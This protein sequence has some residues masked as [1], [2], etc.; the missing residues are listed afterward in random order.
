MRFPYEVDD[1]DRC[2][3]L[4]PGVVDIFSAA[5]PYASGPKRIDG[6][7]SGSG[8]GNGNG[9]SHHRDSTS[10][11]PFAMA[12]TLIGGASDGGVG[13]RKRKRLCGW[14]QPSNLT[15]AQ[16]VMDDSSIM[17]G[18][19]ATD[20]FGGCGA[21]YMRQY[22][23]YLWEADDNPH[24]R[25]N[26]G[27]PGKPRRHQ[28]QDSVTC[29]M[30]H[31]LVDWLVDICEEFKLHGPSLFLCVNLLDRAFDVIN[32]RRERLQLLGCVV[33]HLSHYS[34][35]IYFFSFD[36]STDCFSCTWCVFRFPVCTRAH[37]SFIHLPTD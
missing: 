34:I 37:S 8:G 31:C 18:S 5:S 30:R 20:H 13:G 6:G 29:D 24:H 22:V 12:S 32:V 1:E 19:G 14:E 2:R 26:Q 16:P 28:P 17:G 33:R 15:C 11:V 23:A 35:S 36:N 7:G 21:S 9:N 25:P 3:R 27:S 10:P 4:P